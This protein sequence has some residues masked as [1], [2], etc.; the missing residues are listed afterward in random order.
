MRDPARAAAVVRACVRAADRPVTVKIRKGWDPSSVN[1]VEVA[2]A[3]E[4]EGAALVAVHARTRDQMYAGSA[5]WRI[6]SD[7]KAAVRIPVLGNGDVHGAVEARRMLLQTGV[8]GV[9]VGRAAMGDPWIFAR[10][11]AE[12]QPPGAQEPRPSGADAGDP[13]PAERIALIRRHLDLAVERYGEGTAV[14]EFRR[15][16]GWYMKGVRGA[17]RLRTAA[18]QAATRAQMEE[19]LSDLL[20]LLSGPSDGAKPTLRSVQSDE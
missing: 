5:D 11:K 2:R 7:V 6:L 9:M 17:A 16:A 14:K 10:I 18:V 4:A 13:S 8:D 3:C 15:Q 12:L 19:V 20:A 1:A